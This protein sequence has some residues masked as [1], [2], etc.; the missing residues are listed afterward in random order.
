MKNISEYIFPMILIILQF[1][2]SIVYLAKG[3]FRMF[4][5]WI[6]AAILNTAVTL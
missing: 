1:G 6:A 3:D 2:A 5:Y 4:T